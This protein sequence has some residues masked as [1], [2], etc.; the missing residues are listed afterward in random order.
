MRRVARAEQAQPYG[1]STAI[2]RR[3]RTR[4]SIVRRSADGSWRRASAASNAP[5]T[6]SEVAMLTAKQVERPAD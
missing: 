5:S 4:M 1:A 3:R 2:Q 6:V